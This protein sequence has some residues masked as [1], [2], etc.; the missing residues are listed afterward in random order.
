MMTYAGYEN[1]HYYVR[2]T[3]DMKFLDAMGI[4]QSGY[5]MVMGYMLLIKRRGT[6]DINTR[7]ESFSHYEAN[8]HDDYFKA[9]H[10]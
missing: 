1:G 5:R 7:K 3:H 8:G 9:R 10:A 2:L 4:F 6:A